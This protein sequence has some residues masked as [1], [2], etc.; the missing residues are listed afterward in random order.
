MAWLSENW[1]I[2]W[3][4]GSGLLVLWLHTYARRHPETQFASHWE[5]LQYAAVASA[6]FGGISILLNF[7]LQ[8]FLG[9]ELF[10]TT[11]TPYVAAALSI[12][13]WFAA[14]HLRRFLPRSRGEL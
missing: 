14:P 13:A 5:R 6:V 2:L 3:G 4:V 1:Y 11:A 7:M 8:G 9:F 12:I 10:P